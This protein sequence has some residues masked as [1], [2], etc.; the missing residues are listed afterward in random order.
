M[1]K[2]DVANSQKFLSFSKDEQDVIKA[3]ID[4]FKHYLFLNKKDSRYAE[5]AQGKTYEEKQE[6]FSKSLMT[7]AF[8]RAGVPQS[9]DNATMLQSPNVKWAMF[10]L[11]SEVLNV[12]VPS[13]VIDNF[14]QFAEVRN[15]GWGDN[16]KFTIPNPNLF[17]VSKIANGIRKGEP[18][19]L[20]NSELTL[21]P[22]P[23]DVTI[24]E[25]FYRV[26]AGKVNFGEWITRLGQS[27]ETQISTDVY[28]A[29]YNS[30]TNLNASFKEAAFAS[31]AFVKLAQRVEASNRGARVGVFGTRIALSKVVPNANFTNFGAGA[32]EEYIR[33]GFLG[34]YMGQNL[35]MLDQ[36]IKPNDS[37]YSFAIADDS[38]YFVSLGADR[39][40]KIGF[41]GTPII[42]QTQIGQNADNTL[43]YSYQQFWDTAIATSAKFGVMRV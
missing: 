17:V 29:F 16:L 35:Y 7:E 8:K 33:M 6:L 13:T 4:L 12:I 21:T 36:R 38:L 1:S 11:V 2:M 9:F 37:A 15:V 40:V 5:Y 10:A 30:Y 32:G 26:L 20:Y 3:G 25:D 18:Q 43:D 34:N 14:G 24:Q 39:P 28:N 42:N 23:H 31:D 19:R 27:V 41:E 22:V